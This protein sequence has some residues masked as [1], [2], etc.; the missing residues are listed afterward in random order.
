MI[1][2]FST[3][4]WKLEANETSF[5]CQRKKVYP[6]RILYLAKIAFEN[7][8]FKIDKTLKNSLPTKRKCTLQIPNKELS[9]I[10]NSWENKTIKQTHQKKKRYKMA[11]KYSIQNTIILIIS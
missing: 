11:T 2:N 10:N 5:K 1:A 3:E 4:K 9:K 8:H 6:P 7:R